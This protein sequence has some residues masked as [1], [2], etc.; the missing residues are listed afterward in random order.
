M[1]RPYRKLAQRFLVRR[2]VKSVNGNCTYREIEQA[3]GIH[4]ET[5]R[6]ICHANSYAVEHDNPAPRS[7][8]VPVDS[9]IAMRMPFARNMY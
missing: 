5:V 6:K 2:Y 9:F 7:R 4:R 8:V 1:R 3:T